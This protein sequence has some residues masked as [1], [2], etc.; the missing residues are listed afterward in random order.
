M[1]TSGYG[2]LDNDTA[3]DVY[4]AFIDLYNV[5]TPIEEIRPQV[6]AQYSWALDG[7]F[8]HTNYWCALAQAQWECKALDADVLAKVTTIVE[9]D[10]EQESWDEADYPKR[11][12]ALKRFLTKI[13]K[14]KAKPKKRVAPKFFD[15]PFQKGDCIAFRHHSGFFGGVLCL[16]ATEEPQQIAANIMALLRIRQTTQPAVTD[17]LN[18][19]LLVKSWG[20]VD[21]KPAAWAATPTPAISVVGVSSVAELKEAR[22]IEVVGRVDVERAF[23]ESVY[24]F[25]FHWGWDDTL[26]YQ[27]GWEAE[28]PELEINLSFPVKKF[29]APLEGDWQ[30]LGELFAAPQR[31]SKDFDDYRKQCRAFQKQLKAMGLS[32]GQELNQAVAA[33]A[34]CTYRRAMNRVDDI[35]RNAR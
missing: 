17:F 33:F 6:E 13:R 4:G 16:G 5:E 1:G 18:S 11:R 8:D 10:T 7:Q 15:A 9:N 26:D 23:G 20:E 32:A 31:D 3:L 35:L 27:F 29:I 12:T 2:I 28:H 25:N 30:E 19:H 21:G 14:E 22:A 24:G 34:G